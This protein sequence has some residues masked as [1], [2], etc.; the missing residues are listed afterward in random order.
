MFK[1]KRE[2]LKFNKFFNFQ[3]NRWLPADV[4]GFR[5]QWKGFF[6]VPS[7]NSC[8]EA[9]FTPNWSWVLPNGKSQHFQCEDMKNRLKVCEKYHTKWVVL[10]GNCLQDVEK[11]HM[12]RSPFARKGSL[13]FNPT[14]TR[15]SWDYILALLTSLVTP[16]F[17]SHIATPPSPCHLR[18]GSLKPPWL[19]RSMCYV[20]F[21]MRSPRKRS[22]S[23]L[24]RSMAYMGERP[25]HLAN[26]HREF[27]FGAK[28][29]GY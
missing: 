13:C 16:V 18:N 12:C 23:S 3:K 2:C 19:A 29:G 11:K 28:E 26:N 4:A 7:L 27:F 15:A 25:C 22:S 14:T 24:R 20:H 9:D 17:S 5:D 21:W 6:F 1:V 8:Q 10:F